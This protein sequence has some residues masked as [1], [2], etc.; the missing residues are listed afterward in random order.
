MFDRTAARARLARLWKLDA[1]FGMERGGNRVLLDEIVSDRLQLLSGL[2]VLRDELQLA[3]PPASTD[4]EMCAAD[5]SQASVLTTQAFT[6]CGDRILHGETDL[7][8]QIVA[9]RFATVSELMAG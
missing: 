8:R 1:Q 6:N 5:F 7:Y 4:R 2:Q 9:T 3:T